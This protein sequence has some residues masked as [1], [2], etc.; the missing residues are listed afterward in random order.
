MVMP[1]QNSQAKLTPEQTKDMIGIAVRPP[2]ENLRSITEEG[3]N[4][5]GLSQQTN[6]SLVRTP[7]RT[8]LMAGRCMQANAIRLVLMYR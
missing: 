6:T 7:S 3:V 8:D 2:F 4:A 1:G 5:V